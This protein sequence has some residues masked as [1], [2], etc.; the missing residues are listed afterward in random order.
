MYNS[1]WHELND[2][3]DMHFLFPGLQAQLTFGSTSIVSDPCFKELNTAD[4][5]LLPVRPLLVDSLGCFGV[6]V[7]VVLGD[8]GL[9]PFAASVSS[10]E[11]G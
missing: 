9:L 6:E 3:I 4:A 5:E 10:D 7:H 8:N 1:K 11:P 2:R